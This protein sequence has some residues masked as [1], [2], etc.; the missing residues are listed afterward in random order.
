MA[1]QAQFG[2]IGLAVMGKNLA[3]NVSDHGYS[4]AVWN[5]EQDLMQKAVAGTSLEPTNS[6]AELV[7]ALERPRKIMMMIKA[8][9]PVDSV[10][11]KLVPLLEPGDIVIE[12]GNS[13]Y[14]DTQR[15][16]A[17]L[18]A[19]RIHFFGVGVSGGEEGARHGPSLMPGG[20]REAYEQI[21]PILEAIAAKTE[22][23]ACV[24]Y[25]GPG[26]AGHFVKMVHNGI[27]YADMQ[28][29]AEAYHVLRDMLAATPDELSEIFGRWNKGAL[30]SFL[31]EITAKI[32]SVKDE[33]GGGHLVDKVLDQAGQK[34][35]GRWTAQ[36][37]LELGISIPSI[38]AAIDAR[39]LSSMKKE[40][41]RASNV[42]QG[43]RGQ[44][45]LEDRARLIGNVHDALLASKI[46]AYA[47]GMALI[48]GASAAN[49]WGI[50]LEEM[51]RIWKGGCIIR[52][53]FLESIRAAYR[54]DS[55]LAN[56]LLDPSISEQIASA[57]AAWRKVIA[58][59][60]QWGIPVPVMGASV[61]YYDAYRSPSLPQNLTQAQRD[62]FGA[63]TYERID[64][65]GAGPVHTDWLR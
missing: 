63:H 35:T 4:V 24:T 5:L 17:E 10:L 51:A 50:Q 8:G 64:R 15:R 7:G 6:L 32:F 41:A 43:P 1:T 44:T 39:V 42:L 26:G 25:V 47:Q 9:K 20:N 58:L 60:T 62:A 46:C 11:E 33:S 2:M 56:L 48:G 45:V 59:A 28:C 37:A 13:W 22:A 27:E 18:A 14:L 65:P 61:A 30:E 54:A 38:A 21:K 31:I 3:L 16:E 52:A 34:G 55:K 29:I 12:G 19:K 53:R 57:Q 49:D 36:V 23:G 40:R